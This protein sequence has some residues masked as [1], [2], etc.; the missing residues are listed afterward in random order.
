VD[1]GV[2]VEDCNVAGLSTDIYE[3]GAELSL[4][5]GEC[6]FSSSK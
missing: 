2:V 5:V 4:G 3:H 1:H 6:Q